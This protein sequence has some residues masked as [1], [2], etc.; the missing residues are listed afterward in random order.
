MFT[1]SESNGDSED[2]N[3]TLHSAHSSPSTSPSRTLPSSTPPPQESQQQTIEDHLNH[4]QHS[5]SLLTSERDS[6]TASLKSTRRDSQ[7]ADAALRSE[8]EVL[9]RTSDKNT[10]SEHRARQK[11]LALQESVKRANGSSSEI[12][13]EVERLE[14]EMPGLLQK[15]EEVEEVW[16]EVKGEVE[17]CVKR[18]EEEKEIVSRRIEGIRVELVSVGKLV[19]RLGAKKERLEEGGEELEEQIRQIESELGNI[20]EVSFNI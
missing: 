14:S 16:V 18:W 4:L 7:R 5:L 2:S 13:D 11:I 9:K 6:L 20:R 17:R 15:K 3:E 8:I 12:E 19:E 1:D 10:T